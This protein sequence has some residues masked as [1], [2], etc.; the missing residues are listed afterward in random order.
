MPIQRNSLRLA[1]TYLAIC[2]ALACTAASAQQTDENN[3]PAIE[4]GV[5]QLSQIVVTA[6]GSGV[7]VR[8]APASI[9]VITREDIERQP[10]Y[11]LNQLLRRVPGVSGGLNSYGPQSKISIRG[12]PEQYTLILV[13]G[14]RM[15]RSADTNYRAD[16]GRQDLNWLTPDMIERIEVVRGPMSSLYGSDAMG[17]VI[18]IITRKI[19]P[20][21]GGQVTTNY[22]RPGDSDRGDSFQAGFMISGP[23]TDKVGLRL[24]GG[25]DKVDPDEVDLK[26]GYADGSGGVKDE[27]LDAKLTWALT[28]HQDLTVE[29]GYG[30]QR[31]KNPSSLDED[32]KNQES[33]GPE[34][35]RRNSYAIAHEGRWGF[36][37]S[38]VRVYQNKYDSHIVNGEQS[39]E[40]TIAAASLDMPFTLGVKQML[41]VGGQ[42]KHEKLVNT[43]T[44]GVSGLPIDVD[45][46]PMSDSPKVSGNT[47]ALFL[48]DQ[49][50]LRE[51][52]LLTLGLRADHHKDYGTHYSPRGYLVWHPVSDWTIRGGVSRGFRAP[53][54]KENSPGATTWS[55]GRGCSSLIPLG[56]TTGGC[57]MAGNPD[58]KPE[59]STSSEIGF[60]YDTARLGAGL[61]YFHTNF[62][63]KIQYEALGK[64]YDIWW[65]RQAN[66][67]RARTQGLEGS[68]RVALTKDLEWN[69]TGTYMI[70]AKNL[71]TDETL[72]DTPKLSMYSA[73]DW[74]ATESLSL[75][76]AAN[77]T[78][79][80]LG[81]KDTFVKAYTTA[82]LSANY[83]AADNITLRAG[84]TNLFNKHVDSDSGYGYYIPRRE[85]FVGM[86]ARF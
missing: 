84:V 1:P 62:R 37:T 12:L 8:D 53:S 46:N 42:W 16:L 72:I 58:L 2:A 56:Y 81:A 47:S 77:F 49:L 50:T 52:L 27:N 74:F 26:D 30:L 33:W 65:T 36:G 41:T 24:T 29:V 9:T 70:E 78:G 48:E 66:I 4:Q 79:K 38:K 32:G 64:Y 83:T 28:S 11:D 86:T 18:N 44:I 39:S 63:N 68:L 5:A 22:T 59:T 80:Q 35:L 15:G 57:Y 69:T 3:A 6:T 73:L 67:E 76:L 17:G 85:F 71:T 61:T 23:V 10:V 60:E 20:V 31:R 55:R 54:F 19:A 7:D 25:I 82:D 40:E 45:G 13:D 14:K 21:W 51:N 43:D 75:R 34:R